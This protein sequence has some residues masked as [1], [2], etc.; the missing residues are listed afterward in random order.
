MN[1]QDC[2]L[3]KYCSLHNFCHGAEAEELR[4]KFTI[5]A[6][7]LEARDDETVDADMMALDLRQI[8]DDV[9]ARDSS[10]YSERKAIEEQEESDDAK[11]PK[12]SRVAKK[13]RKAVKRRSKRR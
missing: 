2:P 5:L 10:A 13:S 1:K 6:E 3:L 7:S 12:A 9:D 4:E 8:L 11:P